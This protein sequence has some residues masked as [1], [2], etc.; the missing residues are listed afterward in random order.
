MQVILLK[1]VPKFGRR[2]EV[3]NVS[4]AHAMN[5]LLPRGLVARATPQAIAAEKHRKEHA[6]ETQKAEHDATIARI[7]SADGKR[8]EITAKADK[9]GHLYQKID[10]EKIATAMNVPTSAV[11]L[12]QP[13]KTVGEHPILIV[14]EKAKAA[15]TV[16]IIAE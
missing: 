13:L 9:A 16:A 5:V 14:F 6:V 10:T 1:D 3:K 4:D 8:F 11:R 2:G 12:E 7:T 15:A